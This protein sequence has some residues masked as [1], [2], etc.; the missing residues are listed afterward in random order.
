MAKPTTRRA[1]VV[2]PNSLPLA[3]LRGRWSEGWW[4]A[5]RQCPSPNEGPR[6]SGSD[7]TL[8]VVHSISLPPGVFGGPDIERLFTNRL[9]P[10]AHPYFEGLRGLQVSAHFLIRRRGDVVQF[11]SCDRRAW[12]AGAS[13]WQGRDNCNDFSIGI[14]LEGLEGSRFTSAQY[15]RLSGLLAMLRARYPLQAVTGHEHIAPGRKADPGPGF[16]W[17]HLSHLLLSYHGI[18]ANFVAP[19]EAAVTVPNRLPLDQRKH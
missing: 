14:E 4:S 15:R 12:H 10:A 16:D 18:P 17:A 3:P 19:V 11:V 2:E 7:A 5:A 9:D 13:H 1:L 6:P 8:A